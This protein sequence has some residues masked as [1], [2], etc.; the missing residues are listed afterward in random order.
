MTFPIFRPV[1]DGSY[2][3]VA[4]SWENGITYMYPLENEKVIF[5][6]FLVIILEKSY[7]VD[8]I[9]LLEAWEIW[10][11]TLSECHMYVFREYV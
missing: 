5:F 6:R 7:F 4:G 3:L 11:D 1:Y 2:S 10:G 9:E 8:L